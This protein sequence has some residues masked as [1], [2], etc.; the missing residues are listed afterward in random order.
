MKEVAL[1][2][3]IALGAPEGFYLDYK[4]ALSGQSDKEQKREFLKDVTAFAN[5]GGG[6]I[7]LGVLEPVPNTTPDAQVVGLE[8]GE[9]LARDLERLASTSVEPRIPG[10]MIVPVALSSGRHCVVVHVPPSMGRPHMV[11]HQGHRCFYIRHSESTVPM[12]THELREAVLTAASASQRARQ[13]AAERLAEKKEEVRGSAHGYFLL[14][15]VP[16]ITPEAP[17][18]VLD[19]TFAKVIR[20]DGRTERPNSRFDLNLRSSIVPTPTI[21]GI[22]G[23][24]GRGEHQS[25]ETEIHRTGYI[26]AFC[27]GQREAFATLPGFAHMQGEANVVHSAFGELFRSFGDLL[28]HAWRAAGADLPYAITCHY[29]N[30][31]GTRLWTERAG[32][33]LSEPYGKNLLT[34]PEHLRQPGEDLS[35]IVQQMLVEMFNAFGLPDVVG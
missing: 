12:S 30:A 32:H 2:N 31:Q 9:D 16:L 17:W 13:F 28:E 14:Q 3:F 26:S 35:P 18:P 29:V 24:D 33:R 21:D 20:G 27:R 15:A 1:R 34:W 8:Q 19:Q 25:W 23:A 10:L 6:H 22:R 5:A 4:A 11:N 7:L